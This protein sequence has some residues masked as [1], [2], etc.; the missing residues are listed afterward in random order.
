VVP[1]AKSS[2]N[3]SAV[4]DS[5]EGHAGGEKA[6]HVFQAR[7]ISAAAVATQLQPLLGEHGTLS[8]LPGTNTLLIADRVDN[9][10]KV[11]SLIDRLDQRGQL[12]IDIIT[13][14]HTD[15][16]Q[17]ERA[18]QNL[19]GQQ[20]KQELALAIDQRSNS[21]LVSGSEQMRQQVRGLLRQ[22]DQS[23]TRESGTEVVYLNFINAEEML[24]VLNSLHSND[25]TSNTHTSVQAVISSNA[26]VL[27]ASK[28]I[29]EQMKS[30]IAE[31]DTERRQVHLEAI[32]VE[33]SD[34]LR[35]SLGVQWQTAFNGRDVEAATEFGLDQVEQVLDANGNI[36]SEN[37]VLG[38]GFT[39]GY[40]RDGSLRGLLNALSQ[41]DQ[42][43]L[44]STPSVVALDN[45]EA[46]IL[47]GSNVPVISGQQ[48]SR[49]SS[50]SD[51]F[52]TIERR[53]IGVSLQVTPQINEQGSITLDIL[54][55]VESISNS[56]V[57]TDL[58]FDKRSIKTKVLVDNDE[59]LVLGGLTREDKREGVERVPVLGYIPILGRLF[60]RSTDDSVRSNLMVFVHPRI[61]DKQAARS[62][63]RERYEE[64]RKKQIETENDT[65]SKQASPLLE[66]VSLN[67]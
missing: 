60:Q 55:Q 31:I 12:D 13:L 43:N 4:L 23:Q 16:E 56:S 26:L 64:L 17:T 53:D 25:E 27:T 19:L 24:P 29:L 50:T 35:D 33:V 21:L 11:R 9:I 34:Q 52:T 14:R 39:L 49:A 51:P 40:Y 2:Q 20:D 67:Q 5:F 15:A 41:T 46:E 3:H 18:L 10:R 30:V 65:L 22:L 38:R 54:Q 62:L 57:A 63:S 6:V 58:I 44:L 47:V 59:V 1:S 28:P 37:S 7:S 48:T 42:A 45:E 66:N 32:I 8:H 61:L 36:L